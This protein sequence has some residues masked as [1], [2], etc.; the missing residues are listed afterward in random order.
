[1]STKYTQNETL[2]KLLRWE[3]ELLGDP[4][5]LK[6]VLTK[7]RCVKVNAVYLLEAR[8]DSF[9]CPTASAARSRF[10]SFFGALELVRWV[11]LRRATG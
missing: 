6:D 5:L 3:K 9:V 2:L 10:A 11:F 1:M 4:E 8:T 7:L